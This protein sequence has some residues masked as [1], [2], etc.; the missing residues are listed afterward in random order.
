MKKKDLLSLNNAL[1]MLEGRQFPV[2]F[3]YFIAKNKVLLK[4][5]ITALNEAQK[6]SAEFVAF[7][8]ARATLAHDLADRDEKGQ[9][10]VENNNFIIIEKVD[11]FKEKLDALKKENEEVIKAQEQKI[12]DFG[13]LLE[14]DIKFDGPK[15]NF[16]DIPPTVEPSVLEALIV[17]DLIIEEK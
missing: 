15:V 5:E 11:E 7:D 3:S 6:P 12:K 4:S 14:E 1:M 10:R 9:A 2:K 16:N 8:T 13:D 17:A